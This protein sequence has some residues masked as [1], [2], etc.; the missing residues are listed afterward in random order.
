MNSEVKQCQNC[1]RE[2]T[3]EPRDFEFYA[4]IKVPPPTFC[5]E[6]RL[7]RRWMFINEMNLYKR[8][9]DL[10]SKDMISVFSSEKPFTIYCNSCWWSD[11]WDSLDYAM[12]YDPSKNFFEQFRELQRKVPFPALIVEYSTMVNSEYNNYASGLKNCYFVFNGGD[13]ENCYDSWICEENKDFMD[14]L[15]NNNSEL[16]Y[17][18]INNGYCYKTHFSEECEECR[19][20]YFSKNL[21]GCSDCF[22]CVNLKSKQYHLFNKPYSKEEYQKKFREFKLSSFGEIE[23]IKKDALGFWLQNPHKAME[24]LKNIDVSGEYIYN[25]KN[26]HD[27]YIVEKSEDC[28]Y[29]QLV[30]SP[31]L[32]DGYD[33][34]SSGWGAEQMYEC[35]G[36]GDGTSNMRFDFICWAGNTMSVEYS[37]F[38]VACKDMFGCIGMRNKKYCIL[39]KQYSREDFEK[40]RIRIIEDMKENPYI[41]GKDRVFKYGEFFPYDLSYFDYNE[42]TAHQFFPLTKDEIKQ[43]GWRWHEKSFSSHPITKNASDLPDDIKDVNDTILNEV[44][45][46]MS[47]SRPF[48]F[49]KGELELLRKW[50]FP[51]PRKC[52]YCRHQD[53]LKRLRPIKMYERTCSRCAKR[54]HSSIAS[55][56]PEIVYC[57]SCYLSEVV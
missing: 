20:V 44:V 51:L 6:C 19:D 34:T 35:V 3:I 11:K 21:T 7:Q 26:I 42:T 17:E 30:T 10:C 45:G 52:F 31:A 22:G 48:R 18:S 27:S 13:S 37:V 40:L 25:S 28:R 43:K 14:G 32:K 46:C 41:D 4:S 23:K 57:E 38:L 53:R 9:C 49:V 39:N 29:V 24:G 1:K 12:E 16:C 50:G 2:F 33:C 56:R 15:Y 54:I 8:K 5:P 36:V 55:G 47:C